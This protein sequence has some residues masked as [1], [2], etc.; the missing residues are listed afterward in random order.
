MLTAFTTLNEHGVYL[1]LHD[2]TSMGGSVVYIDRPSILN[3][4]S[5]LVTESASLEAIVR[6]LNGA[7]ISFTLVTSSISLIRQ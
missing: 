4:L 5:D 6:R 1:D 2:G 7:A 3:A